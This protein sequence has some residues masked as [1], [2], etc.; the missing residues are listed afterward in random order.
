MASRFKCGDVIKEKFETTMKYVVLTTIHPEVIDVYSANG[1]TG[2][3][4]KDYEKHFE[5]VGHINLTKWMEQIR[6]AANNNTE[7]IITK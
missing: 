1:Y 6:N 4:R 3:I 5:K 2:S 7:D